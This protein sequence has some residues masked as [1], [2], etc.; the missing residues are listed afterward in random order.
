LA[1][2][3]RLRIRKSNR[4]RNK[5]MNDLQVEFQQRFGYSAL[6]HSR[7]PGRVNLLGEHVD[8]NDGPVLPVAIDRSVNIVAN[9]ID[10]PTMTLVAKDIGLETTIRL[11]QLEQKIDQNGQPLP[12]WALYPAGVAWALSEAGYRISGIQAVYSSDVPIGA[13]LSSSAAVEVSFGA[14]W[15]KIGNWN[16]ELLQ[17]ARLCQRAENAYVGVSCGLMDQFASACGVS[18]HA[19]YFDTRSLEWYPA[20]IPDDTAIVIADSGVRRSLTASAYNDRRAACEEAVILLRQYIPDIQSLRDIK[21]TEFQALA[22]YLP[23]DIRKRAEHVV[24][25]IARV[26]FAVTALKRNDPQAFGALMYAGH[27]SLRDLYEVSTP[28]LDKLVDLAHDIPGCWGARLT[29]AGFGGCTVNL[30]N[31]SQAD[32]FISKLK[33][34]YFESEGKEAQVYLCQA[35]QGANVYLLEPKSL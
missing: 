16:F 31:T 1:F 17:L 13:G 3:W 20:P 5:K 22:P 10:A 6:Y 19:L 29:G 33:E 35:S 2:D 30:V 25:E 32:E 14:L 18:G 34:G 4:I 24:K 23:P 8:Y 7:A 27:A 15:K 26:E 21:T 28:E 12:S 9:R 11:D